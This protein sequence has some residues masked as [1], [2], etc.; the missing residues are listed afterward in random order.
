MRK[1]LIVSG[2]SGV[3]KGTVIDG[4]MASDSDLRLSI[5]DTDR[6]RR[7]LMDRYNYVTPSEF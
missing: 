6:G 1:V 7:N 2:Y 4:V 3:G 5:S